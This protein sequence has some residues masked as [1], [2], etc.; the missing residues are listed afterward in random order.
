[1]LQDG[2]CRA[3]AG[4]SPAPSRLM[5]C[6]SSTPRL[7][8]SQHPCSRS[9]DTVTGELE[10]SRTLL[11]VGAVPWAALHPASTSPWIFK[12]LYCHELITGCAAAA[13]SAVYI[14][15]RFEAFAL[16]EPLVNPK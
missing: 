10:L 2:L 5:G 15:S 16:Q 14:I 8:P 1:M 12:A 3:I 4:L 7:F 6:S 9:G 11:L 13:S